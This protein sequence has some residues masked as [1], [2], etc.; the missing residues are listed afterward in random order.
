MPIH[1]FDPSRLPSTPS[2][3]A[4]ALGER[5]MGRPPSDDPMLGD[6]HAA[7]AIDVGAARRSARRARPGRSRAG[8]ARA[9]AQGREEANSNT[10]PV[11]TQVKTFWPRSR[12]GWW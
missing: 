6:D 10:R 8:S 1:T 12:S 2:G 4:P 9:V 11:K 5:R 7:A 3:L